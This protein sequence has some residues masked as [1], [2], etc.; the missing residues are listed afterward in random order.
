[1]GDEAEENEAE[2]DKDD[3]ERFAASGEVGTEGEVPFDDRFNGMVEG[4]DGAAATDE[5]RKRALVRGV[6]GEEEDD[7]E[8]VEDGEADQI[9]REDPGEKSFP[10]AMRT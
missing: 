9:D 1:M 7:E 6:T 4:V 5:A 8:V 2:D 3:E 10:T